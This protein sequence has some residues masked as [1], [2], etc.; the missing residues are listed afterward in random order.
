MA[1]QHEE[2]NRNQEFLAVKQ[3]LFFFPEKQIR[4]A[5]LKGRKIIK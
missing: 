4:F 5:A 1:L 3:A 2:K